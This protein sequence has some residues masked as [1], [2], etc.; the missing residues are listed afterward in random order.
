M[1]FAINEN[2]IKIAFIK[3]GGLAAGG[4]EKYLQTLAANLPKEQFEVD[5]YYT[6]AAPLL[7]NSWTHPDTN[8]DRLEYMNLHDINLVHVECAARDDRY[9]PPYKWV[10][11]NFWSLFDEGKYDIVQTGR[12]GYREF[13]FDRMNNSIF[14]DSIHGYGGQGIEKRENIAKTVLLSNTHVKKWLKNGGDEEKIEVIPPLVEMP[15]KTPSTLRSDLDVD[16]NIHIFG[17]HQGDRDDIFS[18]MPLEAYSLIESD[19]TLFVM[20]GGSSKYR[21]QSNSLGIKNIKFLDFTGD[22]LSISNFVSGLDVFAHGRH[23]GEVCSAAIIEALYHGKPIVSHPALNMGHVEQIEGCGFV[24]RTITEYAGI[25]KNLVKN[26]SLY[27]ILS[28]SAI[29]KYNTLY[30]LESSINKYTN[31][32]RSI[33]NDKAI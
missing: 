22:A 33:K 1:A 18:S 27:D 12:S 30:S 15:P 13:P 10:D 8:Y 23:D 17:M 4:T 25:M 6:H 24:A 26:L 32:Y 28:Q 31:L 9:G 7:G 20:L 5:Y 21:R 11:T 14:V 29:E 2:K 3:F 19:E 16:A